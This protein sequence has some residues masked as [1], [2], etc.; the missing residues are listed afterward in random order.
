MLVGSHSPNSLESTFYCPYFQVY[1]NLQE[2]KSNTQIRRITSN[3]TQLGLINNRKYAEQQQIQQQPRGQRN[4]SPPSTR[5]TKL[6]RYK[7]DL[8]DRRKPTL[9]SAQVLGLI[10]SPMQGFSNEIA[11]RLA[12]EWLKVQ[13]RVDFWVAIE[14]LME[15]VSLLF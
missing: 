4:G 3:R 2:T 7:S 5:T 8:M 11:S 15:D 9:Q 14:E 1:G 10:P 6:R 12:E 13:R